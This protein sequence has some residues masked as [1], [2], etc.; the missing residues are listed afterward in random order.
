MKPFYLN[1]SMALCL[2]MLAWIGATGFVIVMLLRGSAIR[3]FNFPFS[4]KACEIPVSAISILT[5]MV[6]LKTQ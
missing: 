3:Q 2:L 4:E 5:Y 1:N 6:L